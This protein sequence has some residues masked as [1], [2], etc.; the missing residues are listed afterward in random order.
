MKAKSR[1]SHTIPIP[2]WILSLLAILLIA[3]ILG[4]INSSSISNSN[5]WSDNYSYITFGVLIAIAC[6]FIC[7]NDPKS[8][9]YT[10]LLC[11]IWTPFIAI[12]DEGFWTTSLGVICISGFCLSIITAIIGAKIGQRAAMKDTVSEE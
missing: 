7:W 4:I 1:K 2:S 3:I 8:V 9:W 10:P 5:W 6:F 12:F 11:N